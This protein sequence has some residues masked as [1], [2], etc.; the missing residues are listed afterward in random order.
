MRRVAGALLALVAAAAPGSALEPES[1]LVFVHVE[2]NVGGASGGHAALRVEDT[3]YHVQ[4]A[5]DG[6]FRLVRQDW[7]QFR[8]VY[9]GLQNRSLHLAH[10]GVSAQDRERVQLGL[11]RAH[12]VQEMA[13]A[14][15]DRL[16]LD[17]AWLAAWAQGHETPSARGAGLLAPGR[18]GDPHAAALRE[19]VAGRAGAGFL[20]AEVE[21]LSE[22]AAGSDPGGDLEALRETLL[23]REALVSLEEARA[24][25][26]GAVLPGLPAT[27]APLGAAERRAL[28][29]FARDQERAVLDLVVSERPDRGHPLHLAIARW[30]ALRRSLETGTL[31]LLDPFPDAALPVAQE[32]RAGPGATGRL[33]ADAASVLREARAALLSG[34]ELAE[35][36]YNLLELAAGL[37]VELEGAAR[38]GPL[39]ELPARAAP[40]RGRTLGRLPAPADPAALDRAVRATRDALDRERAGLRARYGYDVLRRNCITELVRLVNDPFAGP[41]EAERAL[42]GRLEPGAELGFVP[43]VFFQQVSARLRVTRVEHVASHRQRELARVRAEDPALARRLRE[44]GTLS[45]S[46]YTPRRHD[47][48]FLLFTDDVVWPRPVLG[49]LNLGYALGGG[50]LGLAA[51]PFD[52]GARLRAA[53]SGVLFSVPELVFLNFRKGSFEYVEPDPPGSG[54]GA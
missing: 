42:G 8:H 19:R 45:S 50:A 17:L 27:L 7:G 39:R 3:V 10:V 43:F 26:P 41:G 35:P 33:A 4:Q 48:T 2:A 30:L 53:L 37:A 49:A 14:R 24:L 20:R 29:G 15:R 47:G 23:A 52:R 28:E 40:G 25:A 11:A 18:P 9:A 32:E 22:R 13:L 54:P 31:V 6:L 38:G 34:G 1:E 21:R 44:A 46:I 36:A 51:A 5:G 12:V 16:E